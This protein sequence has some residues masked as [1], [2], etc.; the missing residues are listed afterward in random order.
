M[1]TA[2]VV[3]VPDEGLP[4]A[5]LTSPEG[6]EVSRDPQL[7]DVRR[8]C[9][10]IAS[11]LNAQASAQYL[12]A[13]LNKNVEPTPAEVMREALAARTSDTHDHEH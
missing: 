10:E 8:A 13:M 5:I 11:D 9:L 7:S 2:F 12:V 6:L 3:V 1:S 4:F